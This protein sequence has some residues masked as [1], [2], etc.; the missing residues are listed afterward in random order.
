MLSLSGAL[1]W[2]GA[3]RPPAFQSGCAPRRPPLLVAWSILCCH[4]QRRRHDAIAEGKLRGSTGGGGVPAL[5]TGP[6]QT[7]A[8]MNV[9]PRHSAARRS[10]I[11]RSHCPPSGSVIAGG[12][13]AGAHLTLTVARPPRLRAAR[14]LGAPMSMHRRRLDLSRRCCTLAVGRGSMLPTRAVVGRVVGLVAGRSWK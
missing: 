9:C 10:A 1:A 6:V 2:P 12:A 4:R 5:P 13:H 8:H 14:A 3:A 7:A 11:A